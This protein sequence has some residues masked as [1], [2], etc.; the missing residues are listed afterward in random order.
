M[1]SPSPD[2]FP[3]LGPSIP[4]GGVPG[5]THLWASAVGVQVYSG[6]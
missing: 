5:D 2:G 6:G 3:F 1:P 4:Q